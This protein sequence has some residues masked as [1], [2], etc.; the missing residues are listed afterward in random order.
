MKK[1]LLAVSIVAL[2]AVAV[3]NLTYDDAPKP[4]AVY[5]MANQRIEWNYAGK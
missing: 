5:Q 3:L 1:V 2:V 4:D